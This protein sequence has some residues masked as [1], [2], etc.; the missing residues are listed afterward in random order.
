MARRRFGPLPTV[1]DTIDHLVLLDLLGNTFSRIYSYYRETDWLFAEMAGADRRLR[2]AGLVEV[3]RRA[4]EWFG[5]AKMHKG[6]IGDD[7]L[8]VSTEAFGENESESIHSLQF[9]ERG[10]SVLH[11]I[12]N[13]FPKV[14]HTL[15]VRLKGKASS[16]NPLIVGL[17]G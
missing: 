5:S 9:L 12:S 2:E 15:G 6:M 8:P 13:P 17:S 16:S 7:H 1:L 4:D 14:W 11:V 3:E 10:V